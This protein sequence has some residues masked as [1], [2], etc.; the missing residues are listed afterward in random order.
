MPRR[1]PEIREIGDARV[2]LHRSFSPGSVWNVGDGIWGYER[3]DRVTHEEWVYTGVFLTKIE[4]DYRTM[5]IIEGP[6][7]KSVCDAVQEL[8]F[9]RPKLRAADIRARAA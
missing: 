1:K 7:W 9:T 8:G 2:E 5:A 4:G 6:T 3:K